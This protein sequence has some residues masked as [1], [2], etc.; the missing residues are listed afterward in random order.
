MPQKD[1]NEESLPK[2]AAPVQ[3][4]LQSAGLL[5]WVI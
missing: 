2:I 5:L 1:K 3:R 4:A